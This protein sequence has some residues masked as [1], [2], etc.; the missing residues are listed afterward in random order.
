[1]GHLENCLQKVAFII[2]SHLI[3]S[4]QAAETFSS[5]YIFLEYSPY[6]DLEQLKYQ[7]ICFLKIDYFPY[8]IDFKEYIPTKT[9]AELAIK[10]TNVALLENLSLNV[11][12]Y[13]RF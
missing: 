6:C 2:V 8:H 5:F 9:L 7:N 3:H 11:L 4:S 10:L 12:E 13:F 1:M